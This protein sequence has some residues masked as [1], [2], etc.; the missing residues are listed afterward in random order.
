MYYNN[1]D[2]YFIG[3]IYILVKWFIVLI[4]SNLRRILLLYEKEKEEI[5]RQITE[6]TIRTESGLGVK[7]P[8]HYSFS[9]LIP[10]LLQPIVI[11]I[12]RARVVV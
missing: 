1:V 10:I 9:P 3:Y 8:S 12:L 2:M 11:I 7:A 5:K 6:Y 4:K